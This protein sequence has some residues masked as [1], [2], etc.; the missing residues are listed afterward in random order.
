M[1][2][3]KGSTLGT[4][5]NIEGEYQISVQNNPTLMFNMVGFQEKEVSTANKETITAPCL[6]SGRGGYGSGQIQTHV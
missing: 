3:I 1:P 6:R 5:T 2:L 4:T